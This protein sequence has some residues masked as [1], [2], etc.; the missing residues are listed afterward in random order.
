MADKKKVK[1]IDINDMRAVYV[2]SP[3]GRVSFSIVPAFVGKPNWEK[4][5]SDPLVQIS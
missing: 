3:E 5:G 4:G 1:I 2:I